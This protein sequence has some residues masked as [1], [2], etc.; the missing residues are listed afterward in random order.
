MRNTP[1]LTLPPEGAIAAG[2]ERAPTPISSAIR[3]K[4]S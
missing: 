4:T 2:V 3:M 1:R